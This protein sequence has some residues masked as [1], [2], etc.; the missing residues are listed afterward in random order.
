VVGWHVNNN[1]LCRTI[2]IL[3]SHSKLIPETNQKPGHKLVLITDHTVLFVVSPDVGCIDPVGFEDG[4]IKNSSI[5]ASSSLNTTYV[6]HTARL[7]NNGLGWY[8]STSDINPWI[9]V[10]WISL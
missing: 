9:Q 3:Q 6:P 8:S 7:H 4:R 1:S 5:T 10:I 2:A